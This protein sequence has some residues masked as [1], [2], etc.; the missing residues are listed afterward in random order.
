MAA[1]AAQPPVLVVGTGFGLHVHVPALQAAGF[2]VVGLVGVDPDRTGRR[3]EKAGLAGFTDLDQAIAKTGAVAVT[4]AST[5]DT[6]A[7]L[8]RQALGRGCHVLCEK[9]FTLDAAEARSLVEGAERAGV[10]G[11]LGNEFRWLP[12]RAVVARAIAAGLIGEPRVLTFAQYLHFVGAPGLTLPDWWLDR[13]AG[14]GW[15]GAWGSHVVDWVRTWA[16]EFASVSAALP[17][18][19]A[20]PGGAEDSYLVRFTLASGAEGV[21]SQVAGAWGP[22][23][24]MVRVAGT[25]G[26]V[27][28][29]ADGAWIA[30]AEGE[31]KLPVPAELSLPA[32]P[33]SEG[34][35]YR[36]SSYEI[37]PYIRLC[38]AWRAL[39]DGRRPAPVAPPTFADGLAAM[40]V[41]DAIRASAAAGG[42]LVSVGRSQ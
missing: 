40:E 35:S 5:P 6:H 9:P 14:G 3:A 4:I 17:S 32:P 21:F 25:R 36:Q 22:L 12:E 27:W 7:P 39:M 2:E 20:P 41:L 26:T 8:V 37:P 19:A 13:K 1:N 29:G 24:A 11:L 33:V 42:A 16:G 18:V 28:L 34:A 10:T 30:D 23:E 15:L 38:E 31:R